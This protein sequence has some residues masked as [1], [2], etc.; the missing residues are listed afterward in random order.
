MVGNI[1][2]PKGLTKIIE[3][4]YTDDALQRFLVNLA[5]EITNLNAKVIELEARIEVLEP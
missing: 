2:V 4:K 1:N 5:N 3:I